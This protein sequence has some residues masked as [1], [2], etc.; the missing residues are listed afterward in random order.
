MV[1]SVMAFPPSPV[2]T[3]A[4][5]ASEQEAR[6]IAG[7]IVGPEHLFL[8]LLWPE[9]TT[10]PTILGAYGITLQRAR[11]AMHE[12]V[13]WGGEPLGGALPVAV[14]TE[15]AYEIAERYAEGHPVGHADL[16][17][18][19]LSVRSPVL[20]RLL[21]KLG[22]SRSQLRAALQQAD[23]QRRQARLDD[24]RR[25]GAV[26]QPPER[27]RVDAPPPPKPAPDVIDLRSAAPSPGI[28]LPGEVVPLSLEQRV[29]V[30]SQRV[31]AL[32]AQV[33]ELMDGNT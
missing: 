29:E 8:A 32:M 26:G 15:R 30:L 13:T 31:E 5:T 6:L 16:L 2:V 17:I 22:V 4:R 7:R 20:E 21:L 10:E 1:I 23:A 9:A 3:F 24:A 28:E 19:V 27:L 14:V 25:R 18:G 33:S 12:M 11:V